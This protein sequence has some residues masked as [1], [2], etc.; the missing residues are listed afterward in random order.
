MQKQNKNLFNFYFV[1]SKE[2]FIIFDLL[3]G[4][5]HKCVDTFDKSVALN[6]LSKWMVFFCVFGSACN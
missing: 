6:C 2:Y 3:S 1:L 4:G 5:I